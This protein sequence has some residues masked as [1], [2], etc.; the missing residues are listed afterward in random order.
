MA[1]EY[2]SVAEKQKDKC[3][4]RPKGYVPSTTPGIGRDTPAFKPAT[5]SSAVPLASGGSGLKL[6]IGLGRKDGSGA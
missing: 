3:P 1:A 4:G 6:K 5:A 2:W